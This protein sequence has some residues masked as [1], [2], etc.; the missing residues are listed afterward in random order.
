M[1]AT[2]SAEHSIEKVHLKLLKQE[3]VLLKRTAD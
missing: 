3:E 1:Q 2:L